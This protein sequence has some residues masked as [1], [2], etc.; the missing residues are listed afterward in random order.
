MRSIENINIIQR[1]DGLTFS[2]VDVRRFQR[3]EKSPE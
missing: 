2:A 1:K 3:K